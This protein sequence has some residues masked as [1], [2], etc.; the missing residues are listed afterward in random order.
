MTSSYDQV[1][2]EIGGGRNP[3]PGYLNIDLVEWPEVQIVLD[4][5]TARLPFDDDSVD[6]VY[7]AH[8]LEHID[9]K[10]VLREIVR[11]C[12]VGATVQIVVPH[13]LSQDAMCQ[14]HKHTIGINEAR[15]IG[16]E[17]KSY[18][19][20]GCKKRLQIREFLTKTTPSVHI[21]EIEKL[22]PGVSRETLYRFVPDAAFEISFHFEVV[23][24]DL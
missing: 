22:H 5:E 15:R 11:V 21:E 1:R 8:C 23:A 17:Q 13:W 3:R 4:V 9:Y 18:Y 20:S 6:A 12:K 19:F 24:Y 2:I 7:S 10:K 14:G 16:R